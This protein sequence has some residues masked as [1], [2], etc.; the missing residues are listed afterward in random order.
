MARETLTRLYNDY[1]VSV[2][3]TIKKVYK[4]PELMNMRELTKYATELRTVVDPFGLVTPVEEGT[5]NPFCENQ[6]D[7]DVRTDM[8]ATLF[9]WERIAMT[10]PLPEHL[11]VITPEMS[12][13]LSSA[14]KRSIT[15]RSGLEP[16]SVMK[17][18]AIKASKQIV[19]Q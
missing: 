5:L 9:S 10:E 19:A 6:E 7:P 8:S 18:S 13:C 14:A 15:I 16:Q 17:G 1:D 2:L 11:E 12:K 3:P 4:P